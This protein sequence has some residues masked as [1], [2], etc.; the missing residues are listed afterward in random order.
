MPAIDENITNADRSMFWVSSCKFQ[1]PST[2]ARNTASTRSGVNEP[3][4]PS[5]STPA[6]WN[7]PLSG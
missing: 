7:T 1:A 4:N 2:L 5:S 3:I 6:A